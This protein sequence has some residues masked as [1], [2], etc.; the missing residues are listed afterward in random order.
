MKEIIFVTGNE[1]KK[2]S[3]LK[4]LS[5]VSLTYEDYGF[6]EPDINDIELIA[7]EKVLYAYEKSKK[8]C[9]A[10]DAGFY[11]PA[12]PGKSNFP[13]AFPKRELLD[14]IGIDG[15][16]EIMK[17]VEDRSCYFKECLAYYDGNE[18]R[19]FYGISSGTIS[20]E[21]KGTDSNQ[22]WSD[23]WYIF[24][25]KYYEKTMAEMTEEERANRKGNSS[26]LQNFSK[27]LESQN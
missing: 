2:K 16:L 7:R 18:V 4:H 24:I 20:R 10:L 19:Y 27:W 21:I 22:K 9:I 8:P 26:A 1:G 12:F 6:I 15:L 23:L 3:A 5:N 25:P 17:K 11:I 14:K 13:G